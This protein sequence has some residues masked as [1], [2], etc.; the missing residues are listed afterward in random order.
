MFKVDELVIDGFWH[1]FDV[2]CKFN[3]DVNIIIG[4]NGTGKTTF[5]NI[6][7]SILTVELNGLSENEFDSAKVTLVDGSKKKTIKVTKIDDDSYPLPVV[8]YQ[9]SRNKYRLR[10]ISTDDRRY[11]LGMRRRL[12]EESLEVRNELDKL[13]SVSSLSVYRLRHD[14]EY[15]VRDRH[16]SRMVMSPVDYRLSQALSKLTEFQLDLA[17]DAQKVSRSLQKEVLAS[18]LYNEDDA[19][20]EGWKLSFDKEEERSSLVSAYTQLNAMDSDIRKKIRYHVSA[21]DKSISEIVE[22]KN[23]DQNSGV[24]VDIKPLEALRKTRRIID[25]SLK[26]KEE[27]QEIYS[28]IELFLEIIKD[29]IPDKHFSF[30][31]GRLII[32]NDFGEIDH[33]KLS[34]G[35]KQLI[36]LMVEALLQKKEQHIFLADEPEL[37]LHIAWQRKIIPAVKRLNP[38]S[39]VIVATHSPEVASRYKANIFDMEKL[40]G[41]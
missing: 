11:S 6:L 19:V 21:I 37:S 40:V 38:N 15:E 9:I 33:V 36:I 22:S 39:Q 17:Q 4:R 18:I 5:M 3:D 16:G 30:A 26:A 20:E 25:L 14:D 8:E 34:S 24:A 27:T 7:H 41:G 13:A 12:Y 28:Q 29:F 10:I 23:N 2:R 35:E 1:R 32:Q 31:S